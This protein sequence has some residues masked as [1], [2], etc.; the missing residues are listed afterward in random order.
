MGRG[1]FIRWRC[2]R[3][4]AD[5]LSTCFRGHGRAGTRDRDHGYFISPLTRRKPGAHPG[6]TRCR[7]EAARRGPVARPGGGGVRVA[8]ARPRGVGVR[9]AVARPRGVHGA[10]SRREAAR[11]GGR[12][13]VVIPFGGADAVDAVSP[14]AVRCQ[15][16][17][18][19]SERPRTRPQ[20]IAGGE[21]RPAARPRFPAPC[22]TAA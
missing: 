9:V 1:R 4:A 11:V 2:G 5:A 16:L 8:V 22:R 20:R 21:R 7:G 18:P 6:R 3:S 19:R 17:T 13:P 12:L 14:N 15:P 10:L